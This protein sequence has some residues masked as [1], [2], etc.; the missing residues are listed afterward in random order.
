MHPVPKSAVRNTLDDIFTGNITGDI[1]QDNLFALIRALPGF[2]V[3]D[4]T[5]YPDGRGCDWYV[6]GN[7]P[8]YDDVRAEKPH[9]FIR[10]LPQIIAEKGYREVESPENGDIVVYVQSYAIGEPAGKHYGIYANGRVTSKFNEG[11]VFEHDVFAVPSYYGNAVG[12][13]RK[14]PAEELRA[15]MGI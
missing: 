14:E 7:E 3:L 6:F 8:W 2:A 10:E 15:M 12:F 9:A 13:F 11:P 4:E 1:S 5:T